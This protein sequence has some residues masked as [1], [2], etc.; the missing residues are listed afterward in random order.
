MRPSPPPPYRTA[1]A[2]LE[3]LGPSVRLYRRSKPALLRTAAIVLLL[4]VPPL[5]TVAS[6]LSGDAADDDGGAVFVLVFGLISMGAALVLALRTFRSRDLSLDLRELGF[7]HR[8]GGVER[9]LLWDDVR[10]LR[11]TWRDIRRWRRDGCT[12]TAKDGR[13]FALTDELEGIREIRAAVE[14]ECVSRLVRTSLAIIDAGSPVP[15]GPFVATREGL[16][17]RHRDLPWKDVQG[18]MMVGAK[19][20]VGERTQ[21]IRVL[22]KRDGIVAWAQEAYEDVPNAAVMLAVVNRLGGER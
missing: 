6:L 4:L 18:A 21:G 10:D 19:I 1:E 8:V 16:G 3:R 13:R 11:L 5:V 9:E 17:H 2:L 15:F 12:V 14:R 20:A 7:I 22:P